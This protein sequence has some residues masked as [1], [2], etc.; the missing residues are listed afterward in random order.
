MSSFHGE[1]ERVAAMR[2][3]FKYGSLVSMKQIFPEG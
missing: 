1:L 2:S 3:F